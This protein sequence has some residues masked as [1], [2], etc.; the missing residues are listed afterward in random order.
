MPFAAWIAR[1]YLFSKR[2]GRFA[3]LLTVV[4]IV[5]VAVGMF[6]LVL[7]MSVMRG[8]RTELAERL[9]GMNAHLTIVQGKAAEPLDRERIR[10]ML[11]GLRVR[12]IAPFVQGEVI[13]QSTTAGEMLAQGAR[14]RGVEAEELP[15]LERL[16]YYFPDGIVAADALPS[17]VNGEAPGAVIGNEI[18]LQLSVSPDFDDRLELVA[19]LAEVLP[20]GDLGPNQRRFRVAGVFRSGVF[21]IDSKIILVALNEAESLLGE[22]AERGWLVRLA[23][24]AD[25]PRALE[26]VRRQVPD[27]WTVTG[28][29]EQNRKLFAAL[30]LERIAMAGVL[31]MVLVIAS[32][33][34]VGVVLLVSAAKRKDI[35]IL[36]AIGMGTR[37]IGRIFV[38]HAACIGGMGSSIGVVAGIGVCAA[39]RRWPIQLPDSYYLDHLPVEMHPL[40]VLFIALGILMAVASSLYPVRQAMRIDPVEALRYE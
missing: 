12:D 20:S 34:I 40:A 15:A 19:P 6:A 17:G 5:S 2:A 14:V 16:E 13:A 11:S 39:L 35:A 7:V 29:H 24:I 31:L 33:S 26:E 38:V 32:F 36:S 9:V 18:A 10:S 3:P 22:Q 1:R 27:G 8:F 4:S 28:W 25:V 37:D 23:V 30:K 21:D